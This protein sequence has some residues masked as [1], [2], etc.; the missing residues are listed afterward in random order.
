MLDPGYN[1][2]IAPDAETGAG[3]VGVLRSLLYPS[4]ELGEASDWV[5]D[6][7]TE[8]ARAALALSSGNEAYRLVVDFTR[9]RMVLGRLNRETGKYDRVTTKP[10]EIEGH[11]R[12]AGLPE[13]ES[14]LDLQWCGLNNHPEFGGDEAPTFESVRAPGD[15]ATQPIAVAEVEA[16]PSSSPPE[17]SVARAAELRQGRQ[18][19]AELEE[20]LALNR[21]QLEPYAS[22]ADAPAELSDSL[23]GF[24]DLVRK[25]EDERGRIE[26]SRH[27][28]LEER[29]RLRQV[30][31]SQGSW[32][33]L[34]V[35][36]AG[37]ASLAA[38]L[39]HPFFYFLAA[40]GIGLAV[41]A[42][43]VAQS[44]RRRMGY[45]E[46]RL[47]ALRVR[48][49]SV[50]RQF[51]SEGVTIRTMMQEQRCESVDQLEQAL[52]AY[53]SLVGTREKLERQI[54]E[55]RSAFPPEHETELSELESR[56]RASWPAAN[57][58]SG[59]VIRAAPAA[60][61]ER[62]EADEALLPATASPEIDSE[63]AVESRPA[64]LLEA[65]PADDERDSEADR[66]TDSGLA[67]R[68]VAAAAACAGRTD[69]ELRALAG[70]SVT[71]YLRSLLGG[72]YEQLLYR[73]DTGWVLHAPGGAQSSPLSALPARQRY[74][75]CLALRLALCETL[76]SSCQAPVV[77]GPDLPELDE[78]ETQALARALRRVGSVTQVL[79]VAFEA[80]AWSE[81]AA[82]VLD[83][84]D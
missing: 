5:D 23:Q 60:S 63:D 47:A 65:G 33:W 31:S 44:S 32:M 26:R 6:P 50:E 58:P 43:G 37:A 83:W 1:V 42:I 15:P 53:R 24:R 54:E 55:A 79:Q 41:T 73:P 57:G 29:S 77:V 52:D 67:D 4:V 62:I 28:L 14:L 7:P 21:G 16:P 36:L 18:L 75:A 74:L 40:V 80:G 27:E 64:P 30:P 20:N 10:L 35:T 76:G 34:G 66:D 39:F 25:R 72:A 78:R 46:A 69:D 8:P 38:A 56:L 61:G 48:E 9:S 19:L 13:R 49:R 70:S 51:E 82:R 84:N 17:E 59:E 81:R 2:L 71:P 12:Q 22:L 68:L 3:I 11:L 45:V